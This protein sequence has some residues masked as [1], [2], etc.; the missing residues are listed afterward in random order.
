MLTLHGSWGYCA[1]SFGQDLLGYIILR[2]SSADN[3][4]RDSI[5]QDWMV[6]IQWHI[7]LDQH[8]H[9][10]DVFQ[11]ACIAITEDVQ[12]YAEPLGW[13]RCHTIAHV[14]LELMLDGWLLNQ[15]DASSHWGEM[16]SESYNTLVDR[17]NSHV[18]DV[19]SLDVYLSASH[20]VKRVNIYPDQT[21]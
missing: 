14:W 19:D 16:L 5:L 1:R 7:H 12:Q 2:D 9:H 4:V 13:K 21:R 17:L 3:I 11:K 20:G 8:F 18:F 6:G 15:Q 10:L